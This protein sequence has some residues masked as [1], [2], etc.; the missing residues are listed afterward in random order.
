MLMKEYK[1]NK[2]NK[3]AKSLIQIWELLLVIQIISKVH[4]LVAL[5]IFQKINN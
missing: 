5:K 3:L 1:L 2:E 4:V